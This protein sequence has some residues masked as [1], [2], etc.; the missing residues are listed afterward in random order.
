MKRKL[1]KMIALL[2]ILF[3]P[4]LLSAQEYASI[5]N[6]SF[7]NGIPE[8]WTQECVS[9]NVK[10]VKETGGSYPVGAFDGS[11]R[12]RF[13][14]DTNVTTYSV[15]RLVTPNLSNPEEGKV[16]FARLADPI[17]VF[18]H[19]QDKWT[20]DVDFLRVLYRTKADGA[21]GKLMEYNEY[22]S[23]WS[24]DTLSLASVS[25]AEFFQ[26]AFEAVDNL[27]RGVV[28]DKVEIRSA[29]NCFAPD[30]MVVGDLSSDTARISW[31]GSWDVKAF[32]LKV[33][34]THITP[35]Q[36]E[37]ASY[38]A[39]VCDTV[40]SQTN[41]CI[42]RGLEPNVQYYYYM[43]SDCYG[44]YSEWVTDSFTTVNYMD[45]SVAEP[46]VMNFD[47]PAT[48]GL[49]SRMS[50]W[51]FGAAEDAYLPYV[52]TGRTTGLS[53]Y[54]VNNDFALCFYSGHYYTTLYNGTNNIPYI[55]E[56]SYAYAVMPKLRDTV[57]IQDLYLSLW[58]YNY[59]AEHFDIIVGFME[60][61]T[62]MNSFEPVDTIVTKY[63][64]NKEERVVT[65]ENYE[66]DGRFIAFMSKFPYRNCFTF[67]SLTVAYKTSAFVKVSEYTM[68]LPTATSVK[69][70]FDA[71][72]STYDVVLSKTALGA[73]EIST[74]TNAIRKQIANNGVVDGLEAS[75]E[76]FVY[77]R[78]CNE[79]EA[80][81]WSD[82]KYVRT[83]SQIN[84]L[85][86]IFGAGLDDLSSLNNKAYSYS[87]RHGSLTLGSYC[88]NGGLMFFNYCSG[89]FPI[90]TSSSYSDVAP[91]KYVYEIN[92]SDKVV[93]GVYAALVL[94]EL[95]VDF[96]TTRLSFYIANPADASNN[97]L[98]SAVVGFST[99]AGDITTFE[100]IDTIE[101]NE[102]VG[103]HVYYD[104]SNYKD[105][106][107]KFFTIYGAGNGAVASGIMTNHFF[108]DNIKFAKTPECESPTNIQIVATPED[109][110]EVTF[111]WD[112]NGVDTWVFRLFREKHSTDDMS[113]AVA[114]TIEYV[115]NDTITTNSIKVQGLDYPHQKYYYSILSL[116]GTKSGDWTFVDEYTTECKGYEK[117]P[118]T[119]DFEKYAASTDGRIPDFPECLYTQQYKYLNPNYRPTSS[120]SVEYWY[121]P[122]IEQTTSG[123][124][125]NKTK[126]LYMINNTGRAGNKDRYV[127]LPKMEKS[128]KE[129][130]VAFDVY[131]SRDDYSIL[132]GAMTDPTDSL[133]FEVIKTISMSNELKNKWC[134]HIVVLDNYAGEGEHIAFKISTKYTTWSA[135]YLDNILVEEIQTCARPENVQVSD[136]SYNYASLSWESP[137]DNNKWE[138]VIA[139]QKLTEDQLVEPK[140]DGYTIFRIDTVT[141]KPCTLENLE[142]NSGYFIYVRAL[143]GDDAGIWS[144]VV[145]LRTNCQPLTLE[146]ITIEENFESFEPGMAPDCYLVG[147]NTSSSNTS[148]I[149]ACS[150]DY[151]HSGFTSL[152]INTE[153]GASVYNGAYVVSPHLDVEDIKDV[154]LRFWGAAP[155]RSY[156]SDKYAHSI[157]VGVVT[158][159]ANYGTF[160][161]IDTLNFGMEWRPYEVTFEDYV[162]D[163][164]GNKGKYI[165]LVADFNKSNVIYIDDISYDL[166]P[167][168]YSKANVTN[169]T[170]KSIDL[171]LVGTA[172]YQVKYSKKFLEEGELDKAD[173][174]EVATGNTVTID[175][176]KANTDYYVY[177]RS[178]C[179]SAWSEWST[180]K[181]VRTECSSLITLPYSEGFEQNYASSTTDVGLTPQCWEGYYKP[182]STDYPSV[183]TY[184]N[185]GS[186]SVALDAKTEEEQA[187]LVSAEIDV[188]SLSAC[189]VTLYARAYTNSSTY[190]YNPYLI[191]GVVEDIEDIP[192]S[193]VPVDTILVSGSAFAKKELY[194]TNYAGPGKRIAFR[195]DFA[196]NE[197]QARVY[198]DD[199]LLEVIPSCPRPYGFSFVTHSDT[200][201]TFSFSHDGAVKYEFK[202][203]AVGFDPATDAGVVTEFTTKTAEAKGLTPATEYD[204]YV[205][206]FCNDTD[207]S[208]W[209]Y[210]D[211]RTTLKGFI[212]EMPYFC[213]FEGTDVNSK[214]AFAQEEQTDKWYIGV[215]AAF[216]VSEDKSNTDSALYISYDNGLSMQYFN[217]GK[218]KT[219]MPES[220][221]W[222]Y[223][224]IYLE[225]GKYDVS[226]DWTCTG[227]PHPKAPEE[228][229]FDFMKVMLIPTTSTFK[230]GS[231]EIKALNGMNTNLM[232][233]MNITGNGRFDL[234]PGRK[235]AFLAN[236]NGWSTTEMEITVTEEEAGIYNL[237]VYWNNMQPDGDPIIRSGAIDNISIVPQTC[238]AP[239]DFKMTRFDNES[240][241]FTWT[242]LESG[243]EFIIKAETLAGEEGES[244]IVFIDTVQTTS[245]TVTGLSHMTTYNIYLSTYCGEEVPSAWIA[246]IEF[247]TP[248]NP[249]QIDTVYT[250]DADTAFSSCYVISHI[251]PTSDVYRYVRPKLVQNDANVIYDRTGDGTSK[252]IK[253]NQKGVAVPG[254]DMPFNPASYN[255][256]A[257]GYMA[258]PLFEGDMDSLYLNFWMRCVT[259]NAKTGV[260]NTDALSDDPDYGF[261]R[262]I[263]VGTMS[264]PE[265]PSTF[266]SLKVVEY[267][268]TTKD[269]PQGSKITDDLTG[270]NY[271]VKVSIPLAAAQGEFIAFKNDKYGTYE[272]VVYIDDIE[273]TSRKCTAPINIEVNNIRMH[274]AELSI[275]DKASEFIVEIA[276]NID[277]TNAV[278]ATVTSFPYRFENLE[279]LT[280]YYVR[281]KTV[282]G[283]FEQSEWSIPVV[284]ETL[285][286]IAYTQPFAQKTFCPED[287]T[288]ASETAL[289]SVLNYHSPRFKYSQP[290]AASGWVAKEALADFGLFS[291]DHMVATFSGTNAWWLFSPAVD[292]AD[293][294][295]KYHMSF[296]L[297]VTNYASGDTVSVQAKDDVANKFVVLVSDDAGATWK[298][299]NITT[300]NWKPN[301][302]YSCLNV[303][304]TGKQYSIDLN[305]FAGKAI[306]VAFY[307]ESAKAL[308]KADVHLDN[309]HINAYQEV[310]E[311]ANICETAD[312]AGEYF[313]LL[314]EELEV[315]A[316]NFEK[317]NLAE[318][319]AEYD[320]CYILSVDVTP[321]AVT[322]LAPAYMCENGQYTD[323][324]N[325]FIGLTKAGTYKRKLKAYNDCDSIVVLELNSHPAVEVQIFDTICQGMTLDWN[326]HKLYMTGV[327]VDTLTSVVTGCDSIVTLVLKVNDAIRHTEYAYICHGESYDFFGE[328]ITESGSYEKLIQTPGGCDSLIT[329]V[330]EVLPDYSNVV[331]NAVIAN[332]EEYNENGFV[333]LTIPGSY[334]LPLKSKV[335]DCDSIV[336]LNLVVGDATDYAEVNIC[337][338]ETYTFG[339]QV[340]T[341]SGQYIETFAEDS[342]VLLNAT[343]L[344]DLRQ[345]INAYICKGE[346]YNEYGF[347]DLTTTGVY[348]Q[349]LLSVDGCDSTITLNLTV[350]NGETR[351]V[352]DTITTEELPYE[353]MDLYYDIAT[354]PGVHKA[355]I[356][357]EAENCKDIIVHTLVVQLAD[358]V[359]NV[360]AL[361]LVLVPNPV[362]ANNTLYVEAEFTVNERKDM[363][364]EV[365]N[366]VGQRVIVDT[367]TVYP[368]EI[369]GL[370][371]RGVYIVRIVTGDGNV[372]QG[373]VVV[374]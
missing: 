102:G 261:A 74:A 238:M 24:L 185:T 192:G 30:E 247:T 198:L 316:N 8:G 145:S 37:D 230:G 42:V 194:F 124:D 127:A 337:F 367:P 338:G 12:L 305:K 111:S 184:A 104:L 14:A 149:P 275:A 324:E 133:T 68:S 251:S 163:Y 254:S 40:L 195:S 85:P 356:T 56:N 82:V 326:G 46:Y 87:V 212:R 84:E 81:A 340:I 66:G 233:P 253:F 141:A 265:V 27:G 169:V 93:T 237:V 147:N 130:Q 214:W 219:M 181:I 67:D 360:E 59:D 2:A 79:L 167:E 208:P 86:Y 22:I 259:H 39:D 221:S 349:E 158:N 301:G 6:E 331:I 36:L 9:G 355:T 310:V 62:D 11:A 144:R 89:S 92:V 161:A 101:L 168:C 32:E 126:M 204:I 284:F 48:P 351:Y 282:C 329:L 270:C 170:N 312:Y 352:T 78:A 344:P 123:K 234:T 94:P 213:N 3:V 159:P 156:A 44:E 266:K 17:L 298:K 100:P 348:T 41:T 293:A 18:A 4:F 263:T 188:D 152:K 189:M 201:L 20:N 281:V 314:S 292:L 255:S 309:V 246:P 19:A 153:V 13:S 286:G 60:D 29:P 118:Y 140:A 16:S 272:N 129:L 119:E 172:P 108:V 345:T 45:V 176:L 289:N 105:V 276:D 357:L 75:T 7:E 70:N 315:G 52:N 103:K 138:I 362:K 366:A 313:T 174:I 225:K 361:D 50:T 116:C 307:I 171:S 207:A 302:E 260:V 241:D 236:N 166:I 223:V 112:A 43:R 131:S 69:F 10:W 196:L 371:E 226:Y 220:Y 121:Y 1:H 122:Y 34:T 235:V 51:Y 150:R 197:K 175:N 269:I 228:M 218:D 268:Y 97:K 180:V 164:L 288:R 91:S 262:K 304:N 319:A 322:Q 55:P 244:E 347:K 240:A 114:D 96:D 178:S 80:G 76:Y 222:A 242:S 327:T 343:V 57:D 211:T 107:G 224:T 132:V 154:R 339:S 369:N 341:E 200:S 290:T 109:P 88:P 283:P 318:R 334:R 291:T 205:R 303:P 252:A 368:V 231:S 53:N 365:F 49:P 256:W 363:L 128:I 191:M 98:S 155:S 35:E 72:Y 299:E 110:S 134:R 157:I 280:D 229:A 135:Y 311:S 21:W 71:P 162:E 308:G 65:F 25:G 249:F 99:V 278:S 300:W 203:G 330:A 190:N 38:K 73:E 115:Y 193:F 117:L 277:F 274:S 258:M 267:P 306:M 63:V 143:C 23:K 206:A 186:S 142:A 210:V 350:L 227:M 136:I 333:G 359:E 106:E 297:A 26:L 5:L 95:L 151:A 372:Y 325:N 31:V 285:R 187:Y 177:V 245:A 125:G 28:L 358:A 179:N 183:V 335:G 215:D 370:S 320:T 250:Y 146:N 83:L 182:G 64:R 113:S 47:L 328:T 373:K 137:K 239:I 148:Y 294:T 364:V 336:T 321:M 354:A 202:C 61:P 295:A 248:C 257:G 209:T 374:Q 139:K 15:T 173:S 58:T 217:N 120:S 353:Y 323:V 165:M 54:S 287:W 199:I 33:A 264:D 273:I 90:R 317:W 232:D 296:D 160:E 216:E 243:A 77:V 342:I 279:E 332:G 346:S 271:W